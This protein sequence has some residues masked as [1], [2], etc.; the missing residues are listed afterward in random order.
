MQADWV[1]SNETLRCADITF[2]R[3]D[4][5]ANPTHSPYSFTSIDIP[6]SEG[7]PR[8]L[9]QVLAMM[10]AFFA[11]PSRKPARPIAFATARTKREA[12]A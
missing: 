9:R 5:A 1:V 4:E 10:P 7:T 8:N 6:A 2:T 12:I 11:Q 3:T